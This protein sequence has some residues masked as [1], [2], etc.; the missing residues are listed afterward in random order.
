[1]A[2]VLFLH[3]LGDQGS[4]WEDPFMGLQRQIPGL[5][6]RCPNAPNQKVTCNGGARMP[7][8]FDIVA[9]QPPA[10]IGLDEPDNPAGLKETVALVHQE[11]AK[12]EEAGIPAEKIVVGGFS[13][14]G[15]SALQGGLTYPKKLG[16]I[17]SISGWTW[18]SMAEKACPM[19]SSVPIFY[20]YGT[21]DPAIGR[22][23]SE[24]SVQIIKGFHKGD[25]N[26]MEVR[27]SEHGP[28]GGELRQALSFIQTCLK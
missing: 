10:P 19:N 20:A 17:V 14:G 11:I 8:W 26:V 25:V 16:G 2:A 22:D 18:E 1:M 13:Q 15:V 4:S 12:L 9:W 5:K 6:V 3:G 27:R 7:S 24:K 28:D 21:H 23:L